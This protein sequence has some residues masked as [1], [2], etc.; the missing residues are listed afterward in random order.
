MCG[1]F[2]LHSYYLEKNDKINALKKAIELQNTRGPDFND[3][4][5]SNDENIALSHNRLSII[6]LSEN[7]N[8]PMFSN[9]KNLACE[10]A[11]ITN[12]L[13]KFKI[14]TLDLNL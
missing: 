1:I 10:K 9:S 14:S 4:W 8:Q 3:L 13:L 7:G 11:A 12:S 2:G 6:D 5:I